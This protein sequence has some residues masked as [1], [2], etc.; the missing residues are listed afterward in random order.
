MR[1]KRFMYFCIK[2]YI[3]TQLGEESFYKFGTF[4]K[5][6]TVAFMN[7]RN[8]IPR[9]ANPKNIYYPCKNQSKL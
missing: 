5:S 2:Y 3:G 8:A 6:Y 9:I 4:G 1:T 7:P